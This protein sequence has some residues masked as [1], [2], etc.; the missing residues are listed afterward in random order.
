MI[1]VNSRAFAQQV[2]SRARAL[3]FDLCRIARPAAPAHVEFFR[4]WVAR[5]NA[6]DM[7]SLERFDDR[8]A[9]PARLV[10]G[11]P[12]RALIVVGVDY[13][14]GALAP[15]VIADPS[16][17]LIASYAWGRDYHQAMRPLL[18]E[19]DAFVR[20]ASGRRTH[21]KC[22]VDTGP[23]IERD[24]AFASG[25]GFSGKNCCTIHPERGSWL[26]LAT[27]LVP[28]ALE[29]D[30]VE[31]A[32]LSR[33]ADEVIAGLPPRTHFGFWTLSPAAGADPPAG[34]CGECA[35]CLDACP[36]NAFVGPFHLD[37]RRCISYW[38]I[39]TRRPVP[40]ELRAGFG[41]RIFGCD[42]C[43][44]VCPW[45]AGLPPRTPAI[46][47]LAAIAGRAAPP[48]LEGF[49]PADPYWLHDAA[50]ARRFEGSPVLRATR[51]GMLRNVCLALG[52]WAA[53]EAVEPL[54]LAA[55]DQ[56]PAARVHAA[57]ALGRVRIATASAAADRA[58]EV[59]ARD[60]DGGVAA[61]AALALGR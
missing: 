30:G 55:A 8:R 47:A 6:A 17:G 42:I 43:Q 59:L 29:A 26:F 46:E 4:R 21:G 16:R 33:P 27:L 20:A 19:L 25:L 5:G 9:D 2:K 12:A 31:G 13:R 44:E 15:E 3:G 37:S 7:H 36:T 60:V 40:R 48:L 41:N 24:W 57:W 23:V 11:E 38:T 32:P 58:L 10:D 39:E 51:T 18:F 35:R 50:F 61:E 34:T 56:A 45:N 53:A 1:T 14:Q 52:N 49:D 28:E 22:L 54:A